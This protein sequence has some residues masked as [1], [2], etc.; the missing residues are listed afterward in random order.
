MTAPITSVTSV[1]HFYQ[2]TDDDDKLFLIDFYATWCGPCKAIEPVVHKLATEYSGRVQFLKVDVDQNQDLA[3]EFLVQAMPTFMILKGSQKIEEMKGANPA[4]LTALLKK[5][6][7]AST[8]GS[9]SSGA[10]STP[11]EK[12]LEGFASLNSSID[13]S[14]IHCLNEASDHTIKDLLRGGGDKWLESDADEQ[15][16]L[17]IPINQSIKLRA[18]RFTTTP[19][20]SKSAPKSIRLFVNQSSIGFDEAE[21]Q[22]PA[23]ALE[24]TEAQ[25]E[26]KEAVQ[27]RFVR[28]QNVSH[29]SIFVASNQGEEEVTRI[30]KLDLIGVPIEGTADLAGL[31]KN[32]DE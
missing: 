4:A 5:H 2:L 1:R 10:A 23:Q 26:G 25:A 17:Q 6:A 22:E 16:L 15:L 7:P 9:S 28:F 29:L 11:A 20:A 18:L 3:Q 24:L 12:G 19:T 14:Q 27:L 21:S 30:D 32:D 31:Q 13:L 8:G